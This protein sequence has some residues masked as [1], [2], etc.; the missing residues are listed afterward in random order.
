M[1]V[2]PIGKKIKKIDFK[3]KKEIFKFMKIN[4][5]IKISN[6]LVMNLF[7]QI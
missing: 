4:V 6:I 7:L 3:K 2:K 1:T 5:F